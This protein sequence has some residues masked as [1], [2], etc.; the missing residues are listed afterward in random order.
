M[1]RPR[2][3]FPAQSG[4][5]GKPTNI[6]NVE[7]YANVP[8][9]IRQGAEWYASIGTEKSKGTKIFSLA[10]KINNTGLVE[11]PI[12]IP[13]RKI[14]FDIGG[15]IPGGKRFKAV[16]MGGP[17]GGCVPE[18]YL[19]LPVDYD[20]LQA[21]G[22]IMGSGGMVV[23]DEETCMVDLARY[24]LSFTQDESCGKCSVCRLGT[25]QMLDMLT[26]MTMGEGRKEDIEALEKLAKQVRDIAL[27]GLGRTCPNP[28]LTTIRYFRDEYE[29]HIEQQRC[30][31]LACAE[32]VSYYILPERCEGCGICLRSCPSKA[33]IGGKRMVHIIDQGKCAKCGICF[34]LCPPRFN[35]VAKVSGEAIAVPKEPIPVASARD[36]KST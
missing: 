7:T 35:A 28:V 12:G 11:V 2:P 21:I 18:Q 32:L 13:M 8:I 15:G 24:F 22:A 1:P 26:R 5:W 36:P 29:A 4:L 20:S 30:P 14:I 33:I 25:K 16:Q 31:A 6:N 3:P 9:I 10:G 34:S 17:S 27:C 23:M 19:D